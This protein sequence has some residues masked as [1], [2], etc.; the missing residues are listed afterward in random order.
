ME[1]KFRGFAPHDFP[2][3][4]SISSVKNPYPVAAHSI[5]PYFSGTKTAVWQNLPA[6]FAVNIQSFQLFPPGGGF[7]RRFG[8]IRSII[9]KLQLLFSFIFFPHYD[10][11]LPQWTYQ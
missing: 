2:H 3:I 5:L 8:T 1:R 10:I 4:I 6:L 11:I 7:I 9:A